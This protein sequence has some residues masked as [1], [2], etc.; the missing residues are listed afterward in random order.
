MNSFTICKKPFGSVL[1]INQT[2]NVAEIQRLDEWFSRPETIKAPIYLDMGKLPSID[3]QFFDYLLGQIRRLS[4]LGV[5]LIL[6]R[7]N[8]DLRE[9]FRRANWERPV[10]ILD[11]LDEAIFPQ[12]SET[13]QVGAVQPE[14]KLPLTHCPKCQRDL[15]KGAYRCLH[16]GFTI[17]QR[18]H[19]RHAAAIPFFYGRVSNQQFLNSSWLGGVTEDLDLDSFSGVGFFSPRDIPRGAEIHL[20]F[21][22]LQWK[23]NDTL[24]QPNKLAIFTGRIKHTTYAEPWYRIGVALF[25]LFEYEGSFDV[26]TEVP[27][28]THY[29]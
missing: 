17:I 14:K 20:V 2:P 29:E 3:E 27:G 16:C 28:D 22:T 15:R 10:M 4:V 13:P 12:E 7:D 1:W 5:P 26:S 25:D 6:V 24:R 19:E 9:A 11:Y 18:R 21:P 8:P 23:K